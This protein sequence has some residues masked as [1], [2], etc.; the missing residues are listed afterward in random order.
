MKIECEKYRFIALFTGNGHPNGFD[1]RL[2]LSEKVISKISPQELSVGKWTIPVLSYELKNQFEALSSPNYSGYEVD[3][4]QFIQPEVMDDFHTLNDLIVDSNAN[5]QEISLKP[6]VSKEEYLQ[7]AKLILRHI[8]F[9][10]IYELNYCIEFFAENVTIDPIRIFQ[11]YNAM[12]ESP[13]SSYVKIDHLH[14]ISASPERFLQR[15]GNVLISQP[16]KGT[17]KRMAD[18]IADRQAIHEL[19]SDAKERAENI[20]IVDLVRNDLSRIATKNSVHVDELCKI[21]SFNTVHQSISTV[22]CELKDNPDFLEILRATFPMGS[23]TGAPKV[24]AMELIDQYEANQRGIYSGSVGYIHPNG[25]F[26][27]NV[28]IRT[29]VYD[30]KKKYLSFMVGSALTAGADPEKEYEECL[31][32]AE[33]MI[34][35]LNGKL[36]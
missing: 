15:K 23:M 4:I 10:D 28:M 1:N 33:A 34:K 36:K 21:Y 31:V 6:R 22:R 32:K 12:A 7:N 25:D 29:I 3:P 18:P 13:M 17:R 19:Q 35:S 26:D 27:M 5:E 20:M 24:R 16:I 9:G 11:R 8:Q 30:E 14:I 2:F